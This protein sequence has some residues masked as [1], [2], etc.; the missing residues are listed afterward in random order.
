MSFVLSESCC[1]FLG[2]ASVKWSIVDLS[3]EADKM[4]ASCADRPKSWL[5]LSCW[6]SATRLARLPFL[7]APASFESALIR[8]CLFS[9]KQVLWEFLLRPIYRCFLWG[10]VF[11]FFF[12][13]V[14]S[15]SVNLF[16]AHKVH[17]HP[18]AQKPVHTSLICSCMET[19]V[20]R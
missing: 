4:S 3:W 13:T 18:T 14:F 11:F 1:T 6:H 15:S 8:Y 5:C 10:K 20:Q 7:Q 12:M 2:S 16:P 9:W 17:L 19:E